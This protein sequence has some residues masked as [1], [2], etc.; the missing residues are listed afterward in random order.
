MA[1]S[2]NAEKGGAAS[3]SVRQLI[4]QAGA[5]CLDVDYYC[6]VPQVNDIDEI[7]HDNA[8]MTWICSQAKSKAKEYLK[9]ADCLIL[10]GNGCIVDPRLY[11]HPLQKQQA[12]HID[13]SRAIAEMAL[14]YVALQHGMP[15]LAI[16]GGHQILNV[17]LGGK[18]SD[19]SEDDID[20]YMGYSINQFMKSSELGKIAFN[21]QTHCY[22]NLDCFENAFFGAHSQIVS[23]QDIGGKGL[24][25]GQNLLNIAAI[26]KNDYSIEAMESN[27]GSPIYSL[28]FHPEVAAVGMFSVIHNKVTYFPPTQASFEINL[29]IIGA[30]KQASETFAYKKTLNHELQNCISHQTENYPEMSGK[31]NKPDTKSYSSYLSL[32]NDMTYTKSKVESINCK[33]IIRYYK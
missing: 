2:Y 12:E 13:L 27:F 3:N 31:N 21:H 4:A 11:Q 22:T 28:Q 5:T 24:V 8:R 20:M 19:V 7:Y 29:N 25:F 6:I 33:P 23:L 14:A 32:F 26:S 9:N 15:L 10:P 17:F 1:I 30:F 16:C 18:I